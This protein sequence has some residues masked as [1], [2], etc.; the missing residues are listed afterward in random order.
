MRAWHFTE[1]PYPHYPQDEPATRIN[2]P[3]KFFDPQT[4]ADLYNRYL[5]EHM[6]ADELGLDI[7]LNEHHQTPSCMDACAPLTAAILARQTKN[8]RICVLGN[9]I[10]HRNDPIRVAEEMAM[11]DCISRGRLECGFVRGVPYE[12]Y[13]ANTNPTYTG[14]KL[15]DGIDL[16]IKAWGKVE[17][18]FNYEGRFWHRRSVNVWPRPFQAPHP[19]IWV[20]GSSDLETPRRCAERGWVFA[21]FLLP[22]DKVR[23]LFDTYRKHFVEHGMPGGGGL[24][25]MPLVYV[26]DSDSEA[27]KGAEELRWYLTAPKAE[28]HFRNPPGYMPVIANVK[29]MRATQNPNDRAARTASLD[30]LRDQGIL[31][32]GTPDNVVKQIKR[33]YDLVGGFD[34]L[35]M[36]DHA[37]FMGHERT[38]KG[39]TLF[40]REVYPQIKDL[41]RTTPLKVASAAAE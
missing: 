8:A 36:M 9:P 20:T 4:G 31:I 17:A 22:H 33:F 3:N 12:V 11:V 13:A 25:Y 2:L 10:G 23:P 6:I 29:A 18:P 35:L 16:V 1:M 34:H 37:G 24:A 14:E 27:D 39:M 26:A 19:Q 32:S 21:N 40:A 15:W 30:W 5:D 41:P 28:P 38:V 7:M